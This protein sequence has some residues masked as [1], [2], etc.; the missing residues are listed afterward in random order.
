M[1]SKFFID[2]P[3]FS[4]VI[5]IVIILAGVMALRV[6]PV[7][8]YP[9]LTPPQ[10]IVQATYPGADADTVS[11]T[12]A[13]PLEDAINGVRD[14]IYMSSTASSNGMLVMSIYFAIGTDPAMAK[15]DVNNRV[16]TTMSTLPSEVQRQGIAI[17]ER[18]PDVLAYLSF[19]SENQKRDMVSLSNYLAI[20][21]RDD[22]KRV[23]GVGDVFI[24]GEKKYSIRVW[25]KPDKLASFGLAPL[26][27][28]N[29]IMGQNEQ[30]SAGSIGQ[31]PIARKPV[32]TYTVKAE[33]RL[34]T[35]GEFENIIIRANQD[36]SALKLKDVARVELASENY[37]M[38]SFYKTQP[39]VTMGVFLNPGANAVAVGK[40]L[41][42][43][44]A[45]LAK[46]FPPDI[47]YHIPYDTTTF[48]NESIKEVVFTLVL[49]ILLVIVV[50][51]V[52]LGNWRATFIPVL[53]IPVSLVGAFAGIYVAGFS[54][55]LLTLFGLIL[56]IGLVV[57]DAIVVIEN[58]ERILR[59]EK[60]SVKEATVKAMGEI[61]A[62]VIAIVL[63]LAA[64][65]IP[66]SFIGGFSGKMYQQFAITIAISMAIS[67]I[68]ALT[69]TPA[70]CVV[71][72]REHEPRPILP[73]RLF[74]Q[75]FAKATEGFTRWVRLTIK[76]TLISLILFGGMIYLTFHLMNKLPTSLVPLEDKG[77]IIVLNYMMPGTSLSRTQSAALGITDVFLSYPEVSEGVSVVGL[78]LTA[79]SFKTDTS[80]AFVNLTDWSERKAPEQTSMA[81]V[82][83]MNRQ[84]AQ[85]RDSLTFAVNP[86]PIQ[87]LSI[88][89]GF[90]MYIQDRTGESIRKLD[91]YVQEIV[92]KANQR[93]ELMAARTTLNTNV[94]HY[95]V[96]VDREKAKSLGVEI[97]DLYNTLQMTFGKGYINDLNLFGKTYHV[98][99]Q[100]EG[101]FRESLTDYNKVFVRSGNSQL[102]PVS[103][104]IKM[105]RIVDTSVVERF[106]MFPA[107]KITGE[108]RPGFSG[109]DALRAI[110]ETAR[111][112]LPSGYTIA[113]AGTSYQEKLLEKAGNTALVYGL[114]FI[115]LIL[116]A[117]YESW[118]VPL[119]IIMSTPFA[120]FGAV[121]GVLLRGLE[122]DI[123]FQVGLIT[124][125]ALAAKNAIL[126]VQF[127]EKR[128]KIQGMS[129][130]DATIEASRLRFRP[131]MMTSFS[132]IAATIPLAISTGAGANSRHI[133]GTTVVA[134]M[135]FDTIIGRYFIPLFYYLVISLTKKLEDL[136]DKVRR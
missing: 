111:G 64:V 85:R 43:T 68:V 48:V 18:S 98:N 8:E 116:V 124:L 46:N 28:K 33:G 128:F 88:T 93:P 30:F 84:F 117:L 99:V 44:L 134:G 112:I 50:I 17:R 6:L 40:A 71:F 108:P 25:L 54:V 115:F 41:N 53:A 75:Y 31:E 136:K 2:R 106:N 87:G 27:V 51:Y 49:S 1:F 35:V 26:D 100:S 10:I 23:P 20:N 74:Q 13:T 92:R 131:L 72:L 109:G 65:F 15:V 39:A 86:P 55:N 120:I 70:L 121:L 52:F 114:V 113:W 59:E 24:F 37:D 101:S 81:L 69:L 76:L 104:L 62:P 127:A 60:L 132:F 19:V 67:G 22:L 133:I 42:K 95:F 4:T 47:K 135:L 57:D 80:A 32:Y 102:I 107:A 73:I 126:I 125:V 56:A 77:L 122:S 82:E 58:V 130:L 45:D 123:Y 63:V 11:R 14:M 97:S 7:Q 110:D 119:A 78:D 105:K 21:V 9:T 103:S 12:V 94:P 91:G 61:T 29:V 16:Q 96:A 34:K 89:G 38:D 83:K 36:G 66:A 3:R 5:A 90:E 79:F 129:L 118:S